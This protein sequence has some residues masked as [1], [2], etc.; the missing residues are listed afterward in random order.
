MGILNITPDSFSDGGEFFDLEKARIQAEKLIQDGANI[1]DIGGESTRPGALKVSE[2]EELERVIPIIKQIRLLNSDILI[3]IDTTK[4]NVASSAIEAGADIIND[5]SGLSKDPEM[6][7]IA[8]AYGVPIIIMHMKGTPRSMQ[9]NPHYTNLIQEI[10]EYFIE[11][12][13][14]VMNQG[15]VKE[16][17]ILDPGIGFGKTVQNNFEL[18]SQ[19]NEFCKLGLPIMIGPSRKSF[20]GAVLDSPVEDRLEGT[21]ATVTAGILNGARIVRVH[22]VKTMKRVVAITEK[23]RTAWLHFLK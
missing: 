21:S 16:D 8:Y 20:I 18:I 2:K 17:I 12:I 19:L 11:R 14:I 5:I 23:I 9:M 6:S 7:K 3:S 15:I 4:A 22:D 10:R 13:K 1:I